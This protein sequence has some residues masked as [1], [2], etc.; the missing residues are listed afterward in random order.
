MATKATKETKFQCPDCGKTVKA[1]EQ[2]PKPK[3]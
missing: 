1:P 2:K 3:C